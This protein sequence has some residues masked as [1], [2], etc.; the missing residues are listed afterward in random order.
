MP[1][2]IDPF[3]NRFPVSPCLPF[4]GTSV[5]P[6][7]SFWDIWDLSDS[8]S[9][10]VALNFQ[11]MLSLAGLSRNERADLLAKTRATFLVTHGSCPLALTI[12]TIR[13]TR[14]SLW[15]QNI[16]PLPP[17]PDSFGFLERNSPSPSHPL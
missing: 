7:K 5:T 14:Y 16:L 15:R 12:A 2:L 10:Y 11:W 6:T 8:L 4:H 9:S 13:H 3:S 17:M 1:L